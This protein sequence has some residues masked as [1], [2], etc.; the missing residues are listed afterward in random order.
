MRI[1]G[2]ELSWCE[3]SV[4]DINDVHVSIVNCTQNTSI[5]VIHGFGSQKYSKWVACVSPTLS[6]GIS[7]TR[8]IGVS[9]TNLK[10][11]L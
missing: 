3:L 10:C 2:C 8:N 11:R 5:N 7:P 9:P 1:V 6:V 4:S